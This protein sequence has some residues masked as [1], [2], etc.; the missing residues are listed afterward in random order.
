MPSQFHLHL[1]LIDVT[2]ISGTRVHG[3]SS[4]DRSFTWR[5]HDT[6]YAFRETPNAPDC[7]L[8]SRL[9]KD[10]DRTFQHPQ[11]DARIIILRFAGS[12]I[13]EITILSSFLLR[14]LRV[15]A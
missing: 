7:S 3:S 8:T 9:G 15:S 11:L 10:A 6:D 2:R 14:A 5:C 12:P 4:R 1:S 13:S